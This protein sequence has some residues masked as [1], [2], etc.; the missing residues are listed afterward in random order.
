MVARSV[1]AGLHP[2]SGRGEPGV[3][4][5]RCSQAVDTAVPQ[6]GRAL[7]APAPP[8]PLLSPC[9][10]RQPH[11]A[12]PCGGG[13]RVLARGHIHPQHPG[14]WNHLR[15]GLRR[16]PLIE[17]RVD[18]TLWFGYDKSFISYLPVVLL[19]H[20]QNIPESAAGS[21]CL[22]IE[23][24]ADSCVNGQLFLPNSN[25]PLI[26]AIKYAYISQT[27]CSSDGCCPCSGIIAIE[28]CLVS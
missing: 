8:P 9:V 15:L 27:T 25:E 3:L 6:W 26:S 24:P 16:L 12:V 18:V 10:A 14:L 2:Q 20:E 7:R 5:E 4:K 23:V 19:P 1:R 13:R 11:V 21:H 28:G 22:L 17:N